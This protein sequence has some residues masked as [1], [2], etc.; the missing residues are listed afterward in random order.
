MGNLNEIEELVLTKGQIIRV[1]DAAG[2]E[3]RVR[4]GSMWITQDREASDHVVETGG[5]F[6]IDRPGVTL[7]SALRAGRIQLRELSVR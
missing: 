5:S 7:I 6:R 4:E 3:I 2:C 1:P